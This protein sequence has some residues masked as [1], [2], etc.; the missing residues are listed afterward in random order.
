MLT[1]AMSESRPKAFVIMPFDSELNDVYAL[2]ILKTLEEE[3]FEVQRADSINNQQNILHDIIGSIAGASIVVADLTSSNAN[4]YY[5]L[6]IAHTLDKPV[7]LLTQDIEEVPFDLR[8]YRLLPYSVHFAQIEKAQQSLREYAKGFLDG[9]SIFGN[10]VSDYRAVHLRDAASSSQTDERA[11][12]PE[13]GSTVEATDDEDDERGYLDH[14]DVMEEGFGEL[15]D[16]LNEG[17]TYITSLATASVE[18]ATEFKE[19]NAD[20]SS[21]TRFR[22][23]KVLQDY[24]KKLDDLS[25]KLKQMNTRYEHVSKEV[26]TSLEFIIA[27]QG[28]SEENAE[29]LRKNL[30]DLEETRNAAI[31]ARE[32]MTG[33]LNSMD[34]VPKIEKQTNRSLKIVRN[35]IQYTINNFEKTIATLSRAVSLGNETLQRFDNKPDENA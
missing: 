9:T 32:S 2:F 20:G 16:L 31:G 15:K 25:D 11:R 19:L 18:V 29:V 13:S 8:S 6:G 24:A 22:V 28:N 7:I 21:G 33:L 17:N 34:R 10:P 12:E 30:H 5:E 23:K 4:V 1:F 27:Y 3:G 14:L 35:E 26:D